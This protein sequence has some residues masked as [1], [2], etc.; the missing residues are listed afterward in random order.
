MQ[1]EGAIF[2]GLNFVLTTA[3]RFNKGLSIARANKARYG[4]SYVL[5]L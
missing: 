5:W 1:E 2:T 4:I 3:P